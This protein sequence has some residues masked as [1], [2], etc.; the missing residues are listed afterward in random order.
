MLND[1]EDCLNYI[2]DNI[3][4]DLDNSKRIKNTKFNYIYLVI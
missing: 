3:Q 4:L 1:F 2:V